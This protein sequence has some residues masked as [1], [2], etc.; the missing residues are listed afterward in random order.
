M[1][2]ED[3]NRFLLFKSQSTS[4][5]NPHS[6]RLLKENMSNNITD[7][8]ISHTNTIL[9]TTTQP[10][11]HHNRTQSSLK[12]H[13]PKDPCLSQLSTNFASPLNQFNNSIQTIQN[14]SIKRLSKAKPI[15]QLSKSSST[16]LIKSTNPKINSFFKKFETQKSNQHLKLRLL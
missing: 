1:S 13:S 10:L 5:I 8:P 11:K 9:L 7:K 3:F 4:N 14:Q 2:K 12:L 15:T 16:A 6:S